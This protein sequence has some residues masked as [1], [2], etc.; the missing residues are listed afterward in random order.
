MITEKGLEKSLSKHSAEK[1]IS[2]FLA[3]VVFVMGMLAGNDAEALTSKEQADLKKAV[4]SMVNTVEKI[5]LSFKKVKTFNDNIEI[6]SSPKLKAGK[7]VKNQYGIITQQNYTGELVKGKAMKLHYL[8]K[9]LSFEEL[10]NQRY[11]ILK[12]L[13][14][15]AK[16]NKHFIKRDSSITMQLTAKNGDRIIKELK[17]SYKNQ[18]DC[19][20]DYMVPE[21]VTDV[22]VKIN[23]A[24]VVLEDKPT[25]GDYGWWGRSENKKLISVVL[26]PV[27]KATAPVASS[28]KTVSS[29]PADSDS[30]GIGFAEVGAVVTV[31]G[32]AAWFA[33]THLGGGGAGGAAEVESA[34]EE[35]S[36]ETLLPQPRE[37]LH[38]DPS[39]YQTLYVQDPATGQWTNYETGNPVDMD[40]LQEYDRQRMKDMAW[41]HN[42][43]QKLSDRTTA[44][45]KDLKQDYQN[46]L[47]EEARIQQQT[48]KDLYALKTGTYSMTGAER[49][50]FM[51]KR[52]EREQ[53]IG[54][55]WKKWGDV[56]DTAAKTAEVVQKGA[57]IGVDV[58]S[59]MTAPVGGKLVADVYYAGKNITGNVTE[60]IVKGKSVAGAFTKGLA[61]TGADIAQN[62]AAGKWTKKLATYAGSEALKEGLTAAVDGENVVKATFKGGLQGGLKFVTDEVGDIISGG[63][64]QQNLNLYKQKYKQINN[65][66][67]KDLGAKSVNALRNMNYQK[68]IAKEQTRLFTQGLGQTL[69]KEATS[70]CMDMG[71]DGKSFT[72][73]KF[74]EKW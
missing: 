42:E 62:H 12:E 18:T 59:V 48:K 20:L 39:G 61:Q 50:E 38:T 54:D 73:S 7:S 27:K 1:Y 64:G 6:E 2:I 65:V 37:Y 46:M 25:K 24:D 28:N 45:D 9:P 3:A 26:K 11:K 69:T 8:F 71:I 68:Y 14:H 16:P 4:D 35:A 10:Y 29:Q 23:V 34:A 72:E 49:K 67:S 13:G 63:V 33:A 40:S 36:D 56:W 51:E 70:T 41:S 15:N 60:A 47:D 52:Q 17:K 5:T 66:W 22:N 44:F 30:G 43:T 53:Q 57:D 74:G 21:N 31:G 32:A 55:K 19:V 58:L